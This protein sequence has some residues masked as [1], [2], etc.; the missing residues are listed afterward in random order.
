MVINANKEF[1]MSTKNITSLQANVKKSMEDL[2]DSCRRGKIS[3]IPKLHKKFNQAKD[4]LNSELKSR[5][6]DNG[7]EK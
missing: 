2:Y 1:I 6:K 3:D 5:S 4:E 7:K